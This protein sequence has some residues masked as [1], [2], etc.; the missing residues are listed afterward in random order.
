MDSATLL[1]LRERWHVLIFAVRYKLT[2]P[3]DSIIVQTPRTAC[4]C[5]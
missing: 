1:G 5:S 2:K 3:I 4:L